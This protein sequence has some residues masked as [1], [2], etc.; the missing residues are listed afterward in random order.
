M[1]QIKAKQVGL[2]MILV[3]EGTKYS[4]KCTKEEIESIKNKVLLFNKKPNKT[5]Q[6]TILGLIDKTIKEKEKKVAAKK[7]VKK[8]IKKEVK[9]VS[10]S[11]VKKESKADLV[12]EVE[13][14]F[15]AG[16]FSKE[17]IERLEALLKKK[18]EA[19]KIEEKPVVKE[20][21]NATNTR[22]RE[23]Y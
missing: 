16:N 13:V 1:E 10:K 4:K 14:E 18:K 11:K 22:S 12:T 7:G 23:R 6:T 20:Q 17:E 15:K 21:D 9:K 5:L 2:N 19:L 3:I 8:A